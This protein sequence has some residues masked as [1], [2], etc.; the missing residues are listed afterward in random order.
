[1]IQDK[2]AGR[3]LRPVKWFLGLPIVTATQRKRKKEREK[4]RKIY[5]LSIYRKRMSDGKILIPYAASV[6]N[7][8]FNFSLFLLTYTYNSF[9]HRRL[10]TAGQTIFLHLLLSMNYNVSIFRWIFV[11]SLA[12]RMTPLGVKSKDI[13]PY[14]FYNAKTTL[15]FFFPFGFKF[16]P[17][18]PL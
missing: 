4:E 6:C 3:S 17:P 13:Q 14:I 10:R 16:F 8:S 9:S 2:T 7:R 5:S 15:V 11:V 1:M 18:F 12:R